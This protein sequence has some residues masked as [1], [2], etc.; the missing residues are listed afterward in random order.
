MARLPALEASDQPRVLRAA[1][2]TT[3][4]REVQ[5]VVV[6]DVWICSGQSNMEMGVG[7]CNVPTRSRPRTIR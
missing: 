6:G 7:M 2:T 1:G 5:N 4:A 3:A